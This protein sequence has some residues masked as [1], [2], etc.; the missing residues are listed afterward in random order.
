M[1][2]SPGK[3]FLDVSSQT[4]C[5]QLL[6]NRLWHSNT[7][8]VPSA[9]HLGVPLSRSSLFICPASGSQS[10]LLLT[11]IIPAWEASL[12]GTWVA[13]GI[14]ICLWLRL[15]SQGPGIKSHIGLS[16]GFLL[17]P[18]PKK[19]ALNHWIQPTS[20]AQEEGFSIMLFLLWA[21][22]KEGTLCTYPWTN[23]EATV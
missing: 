10:L 7:E 17:L 1:A 12:R 5:L 9:G 6:R 4:T 19:P 14:S 13:Q 8:E 22:F 15:W 18:L 2:P 20:P 11:L 3:A 23:E 16:M 21:T